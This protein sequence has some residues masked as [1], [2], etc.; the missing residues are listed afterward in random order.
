MMALIQEIVV[1]LPTEEIAD[2]GT[3]RLGSGTITGSFAPARET[4]QNASD[5]KSEQADAGFPALRLPERK[6]A[7]RGLVRLGSGTITAGFPSR[8]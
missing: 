3:V 4:K 6:I 8:D 7:D 1:R 2:R 5:G